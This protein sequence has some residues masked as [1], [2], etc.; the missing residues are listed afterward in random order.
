M[1]AAAGKGTGLGSRWV[2]YGF[3]LPFLFF[4]ILF[5]VA[6]LA[7]GLQLSIQ[8]NE[9]YGQSRFVGLDNFHA[10]MKD[11]VFFKALRNTLVYTAISI[12]IIL[13]LA[14]GLA[15]LLRATFSRLRPALTFCLLLPALTPPAVLALLFLLVF[16]GRQGML[17]QWFVLPFGFAP[18]DWLKDP[19]V[20]LWAL[21][22]QAVWRWT[23]FVTFF[24]LAGMEAIPRA[25]YEA[26]Q[27]AT[28]SR[29]QWFRYV[30]FPQLRHV[31]LFG[32][33]YLMVDAFSLFSGAYV[34]LGASGGTSNAGLL[35]VSYVY[36]L[37]F[38]PNLQFG[39]AAAASLSVAPLLLLALGL[40][41][42]L[43]R[44][45]AE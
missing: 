44:H 2:S 34:L 16:H 45:R 36:Q 24:I 31:L 21:V 28:G 18:V 8:S 12:G 23:G 25:Y 5:W 7:G 40:C 33:V 42:V 11:P 20:I 32:A 14:L 41:F 37:G 29:W 4:F 15:H 19:K 17:N 38:H 10:L 43:P 39:T 35:L 1:S 22:L 6:P 9:I 27:L 26:V 30:T 13:P 3:L